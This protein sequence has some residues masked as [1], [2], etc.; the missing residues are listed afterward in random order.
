MQVDVY[1]KTTAE[2]EAAAN[3]IRDVFE[4]NFIPLDNENGD[5]WDQPTGLY[6][7]SRTYDFWMARP[8][9]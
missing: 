5:G 2:A 8:S 4:A 9:S 7:V 6:N 1:A 3:V